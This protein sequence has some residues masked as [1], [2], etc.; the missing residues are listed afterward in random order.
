MRLLPA[1]REATSVIDA[2]IRVRVWACHLST[3]FS[4]KQQVTKN[5]TFY[6]IAHA[7]LLFTPRVC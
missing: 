4:T 7:A 1:G 5:N 3:Y 6:C 2:E